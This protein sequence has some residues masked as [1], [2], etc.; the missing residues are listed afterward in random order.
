MTT[1]FTGKVH[2]GLACVKPAGVKIDEHDELVQR[3][4]LARGIR[5]VNWS[6]LSPWLSGA[7][8][9]LAIFAQ[10]AGAFD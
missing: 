4:L 3:A 5:R 9:A 2:I 6:F 7:A 8:F 10:V 1:Y